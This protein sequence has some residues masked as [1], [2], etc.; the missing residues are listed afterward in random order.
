MHN[1]VCV[2]I[3]SGG[4]PVRNDNYV[5]TSRH[6]VANLILWVVWR[7][8]VGCECLGRSL[9]FGVNPLSL[10]LRPLFP[11]STPLFLIAGAPKYWHG[12]PDG[13]KSHFLSYD[14]DG[15]SSTAPK[16][17]RSL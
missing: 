12:Y 17:S 15:V 9:G 7:L 13:G 4:G 14:S 11:G 8:P 3:S 16:R 1:S 6:S 10:A 5:Y 2:Q